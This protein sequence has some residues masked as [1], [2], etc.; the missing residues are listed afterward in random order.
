[1]PKFGTKSAKKLA[2]CHED[3]QEILNEAIKYFDFTIIESYRSEEKQLKAYNEGRSQLKKGKH[4]VYPSI[5]VDIA[6][7]PVDWQDTERF[8]YLAGHVMAIAKMNGKKIRWG[9]DWDMD[10]QT[11]DTNFRDYPHFELML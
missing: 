4:N 2:D 6:P 10:T 3:L 5:A 11:K 8:T 7:W 9:N 1:M